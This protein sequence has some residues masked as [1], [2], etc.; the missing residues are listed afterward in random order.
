MF[1]FLLALA[2]RQPSRRSQLL[3]SRSPET[4]FARVLDCMWLNSRS[5]FRE[6]LVLAPTLLAD[7][8]SAAIRE[9]NVCKAADGASS[10]DRG[11]P[12]RGDFVELGAGDGMTFSNTYIFEMCLWWPGLLIEANK[13]TY[14]RLKH[15]PR[16]EIVERRN[17]AICTQKGMAQIHGRGGAGIAGLSSHVS[18]LPSNTSQSLKL[19][20]G[21]LVSCDSLRSLMAGA[22][23][24]N[25]T[26][27]SLDVEGA[28]SIVLHTVDPLAFRVILVE[29]QRKHHEKNQQV[30]A[31]LEALGFRQEL[32]VVGL[33]RVYLAP[34]VRNFPAP[35]GL[36]NTTYMRWGLGC[37][38]R[39]STECTQLRAEFDQCMWH[40]LRSVCAEA[41]RG[42]DS[43]GAC[44]ALGAT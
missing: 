35:L 25:A 21:S 27:L 20:E 30:Q 36:Y 11:H 43:P 26:F 42:D 16:S 37:R 8:V 18:I 17:S 15:A 23:I 7:S 38:V 19:P 24:P 5:Q 1:I 4:P 14:H 9:P 28:E 40:A 32:G 33:N 13:V 3:C 10:T 31:Q 34:G 39:N 44:V 22:G 6:D 2:T 12:F 41:A 29:E